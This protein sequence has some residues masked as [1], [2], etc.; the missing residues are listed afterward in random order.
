VNFAAKKRTGE[1][2]CADSIGWV[3]C[4]F[5][6]I[7]MSRSAAHRFAHGVGGVVV[8]IVKPQSHAMATVCR[9]RAPD[10][11][12]PG[13]ICGRPMPCREHGEGT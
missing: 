11:A 10:D 12:V 3:R 9:V 5:C 7:K 4:R 1:Y 13:R 8:R 2:W 6:A